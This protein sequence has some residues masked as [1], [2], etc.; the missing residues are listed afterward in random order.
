[1]CYRI[2]CKVYQTYI[3]YVYI[4]KIVLGASTFSSRA[5][6]INDIAL[7]HTVEQPVGQIVKYTPYCII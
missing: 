1:M 3:T 5:L 7:F 2:Q 4:V 6:C